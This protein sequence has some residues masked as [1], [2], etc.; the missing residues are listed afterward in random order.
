MAVTINTKVNTPTI[1]RIADDLLQQQ[2]NEA[3]ARMNAPP[4]P[5]QQVVPNPSAMFGEEEVFVPPRRLSGLPPDARLLAGTDVRQPAIPEL[6]P[7]G[8]PIDDMPE[9]TEAP[10]EDG[11]FGMD[12][13][14]GESTNEDYYSKLQEERNSQMEARRILDPS[15]FENEDDIRNAYGE[16]AVKATEAGAIVRTA[17]NISNGLNDLEVGLYKEGTTSNAQLNGLTY[18]KQGTGLDTKTNW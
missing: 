17:M 6:M 8:Q 18:L 2:I 10:Q 7:N 16:G 13:F 12:T 4:P 14:A 9:M 3:N 5:E 15:R 11:G 1:P